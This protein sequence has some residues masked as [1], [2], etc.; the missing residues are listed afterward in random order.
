MS[1]VDKLKEL[2]AQAK[3]LNEQRKQLRE[4]ANAGKE[5]RKTARKQQAEARKTV[6]TSKKDVR[7]LSA[8]VFDIFSNGSNEDVSNLAD[9]LMEASTEL[10][11][12][13][14]SFA[15]AGETLEDL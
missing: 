10:V 9:E 11:G 3:Q 2:D 12:A 14:R 5:E 6:L 8:K 15:E 13:I 7:E 4:E 1:S